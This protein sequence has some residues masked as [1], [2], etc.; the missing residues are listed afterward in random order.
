MIAMGI[1]G[2]QYYSNATLW[3]RLSQLLYATDSI[4][5]GMYAETLPL[6]TIIGG[7]VMCFSKKIGHQ[8]WQVFGAIALQTACVGIM[9][10]ASIGN[11]AKSV[12]LTVIVS[13]CTSMVILNC[14]VTIG[15][16]ILDQ[17]DIGSAAGIA[18]TSRL[19]FGAVAIAIFSN[20]TN[21]KYGNSLAPAVVRNIEGLGFN[22][23]N[24]AKLV[25]AAKAGT[26][27]AYDAVP[28]LTPAIR[29]AA[30][31][32]NKEAYLEGA[33]L[34]YQV[35]LAF[36]L[37]GCIAAL[38][39]PSIDSRK[40]TKRTVALQEADRKAFEEEKKKKTGIA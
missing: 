6:G 30:V 29:A 32:A 38:F 23:A 22:T 2:M 14:L 17:N 10:T 1:A 21:N 26:A 16:G 31:L 19:M 12:V 34:S 7:I 5:K 8:R 25:A 18:G 40:Y 37:C 36:G 3:P 39:I 33:H 28:G 9:S 11:P 24:L 13:F 20:V 4:S 27:T 35:A 15:F